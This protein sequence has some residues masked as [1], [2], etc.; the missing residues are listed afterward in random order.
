[1]TPAIELTYPDFYGSTKQNSL[2]FKDYFGL[3]R[4]KDSLIDFLA[5]EQDI[6][7]NKL[8]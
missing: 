2:F 6:R 1:M 7:A 8:N 5:N 3:Y 4:H